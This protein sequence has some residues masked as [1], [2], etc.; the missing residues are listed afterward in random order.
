[1]QIT[2]KFV[3]SSYTED[4]ETNLP[5]GKHTL[6]V[7]T[8][9]F[10]EICSKKLF[11]CFIYMFV[12]ICCILFLFQGFMLLNAT[13]W[14]TI[15]LTIKGNAPK[16]ADWAKWIC[17]TF[18]NCFCSLLT[19]NWEVNTGRS[20]NSFLYFLK[21]H[22]NSSYVC[23]LKI[24]KHI[25]GLESIPCVYLRDI[26]NRLLAKLSLHASFVCLFP[27]VVFCIFFNNL[28]CWLQRW[29]LLS[30]MHL[31]VTDQTWHT[32][33]NESVLHLQVVFVVSWHQIGKLVQV[34]SWTVSIILRIIH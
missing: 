25:F 7:F 15:T 19:S 2:Q 28:C 32:G 27:F 14:F 13:L 24:L 20:L 18:G 12:S 22:K 11:W 3:I 6:R 30:R 1:M 31:K 5:I 33:P 26:L 10:K 21:L 8:W 29:G 23:I 4:I 17:I 16:L 9:Y 34:I